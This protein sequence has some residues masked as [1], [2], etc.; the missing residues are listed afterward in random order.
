MLREK[1]DIIQWLEEHEITKYQLIADK[2]YGY[3]VNIQECVCIADNRQ[4]K[5]FPI[6]FNHIKG[7]F[8]VY[9]CELNSLKNGP[10][11]VEGE[12]NCQCNEL[13][14]LLFSPT[15]VGKNFFCNTNKITSLKG[16]PEII[17]GKFDCSQNLLKDL[18]F[19]P[20]TV[21]SN[22]NASMN[23]LKSLKG[24]AKNIGGSLALHFNNISKFDLQHFPQHVE[25][26]I[27]IMANPIFKK[28]KT[29]NF[30]IIRAQLEKEALLTLIDKKSSK[31]NTHKI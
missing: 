12:F 4:L 10:T 13:K 27:F 31:T 8:T 23:K 17:H 24:I 26:K 19:G 30:T 1:K 7:N 6:K 9:N 18:S 29:D 2:E 20:H 5:E 15:Y 22:F 28:N 16:C 14:N 25:K 3:V 21:H 11:I